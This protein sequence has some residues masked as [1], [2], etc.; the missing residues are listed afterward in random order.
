MSS[1]VFMSTHRV[2]SRRVASGRCDATLLHQ[3][4]VNKL[5]KQRNFDIELN[6]HRGAG[7]SFWA[8]IIDDLTFSLR[9]R[10]MHFGATG[11]RRILRLIKVQVRVE[12]DRSTAM[13]VKLFF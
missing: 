12:T 9:T 11:A 13:I 2:L 8:K 4:R 3:I 5:V 10:S 1:A 6:R 7:F